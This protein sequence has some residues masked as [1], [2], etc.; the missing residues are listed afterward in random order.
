MGQVMTTLEKLD[1]HPVK[2]GACPSAS[3]W[4]SIKAIPKE[5]RLKLGEV[6][7]DTLLCFRNYNKLTRN[8][9]QWVSQDKFVAQFGR[10]VNYGGPRGKTDED[11]RQTRLL[12]ERRNKPT[13]RARHKERMLTD[14]VYAEKQREYYRKQNEKHKEKRAI[15]LKQ[16]KGRRIAIIAGRIRRSIQ[17]HVERVMFNDWS[18]IRPGA[19]FLCWLAKRM[20]ITEIKSGWHIDHIKPL[21][22]FDLTKSGK[23]EIN[24][25]ENLRWITAQQNLIKG[26]KMPSEE[27]IAAHL[28]LVEEWRRENGTDTR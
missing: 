23:D 18:S 26:T 10:P 13:K 4:E 15:Y 5:R 20:G 6:N 7:P 3:E 11:K 2:T 14:P 9:I 16:Y 25:P 22:S 17:R 12:N 28:K 1:A 21:I 27:E 24:A 8:G 19:V